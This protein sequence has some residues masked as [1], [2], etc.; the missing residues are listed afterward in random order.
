MPNG[1]GHAHS[2]MRLDYDERLRDTDLISRAL[3]IL[4]NRYEKGYG[5]L[6]SFDS[7][8][9]GRS[10][11]IYEVFMFTSDI[12]MSW[13]EKL[14]KYIYIYIYDICTSKVRIKNY[15]PDLI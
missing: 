1:I 5:R 4:M 10:M 13:P 12:G 6:T 7:K 8:R 9:G 3:S 15:Y 14:H 2:K 11:T